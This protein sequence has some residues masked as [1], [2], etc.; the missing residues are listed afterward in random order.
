MVTQTPG[1]LLGMLPAV[2]VGGA[3]GGMARY[4]LSGFVS[5]RLGDRLPWG[6][7]AVNVSGALAIGILA[8]AL[9]GAGEGLA[10]LPWLALG[11]GIL[12][13]YTTVS[14]FSLQTLVLL[15]EGAAG[16]AAL[17]VVL[18]ASLCLSAAGLGLVATAGW[19]GSP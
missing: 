18:S 13:S 1:D 19:P 11:I 3:I 6:T 15:R 10:G 17:N 7:M 4:W 9:A 2:L 8:G 12:G 14:S 5:R 16:R